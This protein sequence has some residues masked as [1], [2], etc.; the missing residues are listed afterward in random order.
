MGT[1]YENLIYGNQGFD[2]SMESVIKAA[3]IANCHNFIQELP[4]GYNTVLA[5]RGQN[6]SGGQ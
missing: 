2:I 3:K 1:I 6:L 4:D 5:E